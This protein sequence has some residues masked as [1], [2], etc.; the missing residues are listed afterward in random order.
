[1]LAECGVEKIFVAF[2]LDWLFCHIDQ[3]IFLGDGWQKT[4]GKSIR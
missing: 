2:E 1:M 3:I 4:V